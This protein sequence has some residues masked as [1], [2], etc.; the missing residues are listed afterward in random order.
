MKKIITLLLVASIGLSSCDV[1]Q[2]L[3]TTG[4]AIGGISQTEAGQGIKEALSQGL[5]KSV[6]QLNSVDGFFKDA[7]Y[8]ILLPPEAK[9]IENT[10]R[11]L[12]LNSMVD[13]AILQINRGAEDAAGY[14]KPIFVDAIKSMTIT[15]AIGLVRNGDT[16]ATHFFREKT[17]VKLI[18]AFTPV[19][20]AS[21]DKVD[22]TK[23]YGDLIN[24]YNSLPTTFNKLNPDLT[25]YVTQRATNA[26]FD[27]VAKEEVNIRTNLA[28]RTSDILKK[29]FGGAYK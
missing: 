26:L 17:T 12:G 2:N 15:D 10:L 8:K 20:K 5:A 27:L 7:L 4:S 3:P 21:L 23:Y 25:G 6:L 22:G 18:A 13:K 9:K 1:I 29:V 16:S 28:A 19:I 24:K 11:A 14:A